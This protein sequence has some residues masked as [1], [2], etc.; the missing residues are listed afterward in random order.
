MGTKFLLTD[1]CGSFQD[2]RLSV[3][4][5]IGSKAINV[6]FKPEISGPTTSVISNIISPGSSR[7]PMPSP[8]MELLMLLISFWF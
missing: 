8:S 3:G 7:S 5:D 1:L 2:E 6:K 4:S